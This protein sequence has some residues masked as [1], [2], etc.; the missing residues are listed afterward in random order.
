MNTAPTK[1]TLNK[2]GNGYR[3]ECGRFD[4]Q[5]DIDPRNGWLM[6]DNNDRDEFGPRIVNR[7]TTLS[8]A[9]D[10]IAWNAKREQANTAAR[11]R[12]GIFSA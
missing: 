2:I 6:F 4:I 9:R 10:F 3:S 5:R 11:L 12:A 1:T 8:G 7:P